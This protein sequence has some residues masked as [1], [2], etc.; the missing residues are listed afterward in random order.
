VSGIP[1]NGRGDDSRNTKG[2]E[3]VEKTEQVS[4][5]EEAEKKMIVSNNSPTG[6]WR[7]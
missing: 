2:G 6:W 1:W 3:G 4:K 7:L 5:I